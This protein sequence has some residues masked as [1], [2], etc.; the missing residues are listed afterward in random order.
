[1]T[2]GVVSW[3]AKAHAT[4]VTRISF[5][6]AVL[7]M[8]AGEKSGWVRSEQVEVDFEDCC[9]MFWGF[10]QL[11]LVKILTGWGKFVGSWRNTESVECHGADFTYDTELRSPADSQAAP[12]TILSDAM[13][14]ISMSTM[15]AD[16]G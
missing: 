1:M 10:F 12:T 15:R 8:S 14:A 4:S 2:G 16:D 13:A 9:S 6:G 7:M 11:D 3:A 5:I